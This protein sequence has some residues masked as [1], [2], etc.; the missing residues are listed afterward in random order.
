MR[1]ASRTPG[2]VLAFACAALLA[3]G[4]GERSEPTGAHVALF[5]VTVDNPRGGSQITLEQGPDRIAVVD[6]EGLRILRAL[7]VKARLAADVHGNPKRRL[8]ARLRPQ[9]VVGGPSNDPLR[10]RGLGTSTPVYVADGGSIAGVEQSIVE[11]ARLTGHPVRGR[12]LVRRIERVR[13]QVADRRHGKAVPSV[14]LDLGLFTTVGASSLL[15]ELIAAAGGRDVVGSSVDRAPVSPSSLADLDP[16]VYLASTDSGTT[17]DAL[18]ADDATKELRPVRSG[19]FALVP[20]R[21]L[22]AGPGLDRTILQLEAAIHAQSS[23]GG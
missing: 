11:L 17:L 21:L 14:F 2:A 6:E 18:R 20:A 8:L 1:R 15:G 7:G 10:L 5:P 22:Q 12:M 19:R 3:A 23:A 9:L 16:D 4:C 13:A